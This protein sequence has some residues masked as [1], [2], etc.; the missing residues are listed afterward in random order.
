M[1]DLP[2]FIKKM[3]EEESNLMDLG[4]V[5]VQ[6]FTVELD[7]EFEIESDVFQE[8]EMPDSAELFADPPMADSIE[9]DTPTV[10]GQ[11][12]WDRITAQKNI[13]NELKAWLKQCYKQ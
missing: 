12:Y 9:F 1:H 4:M 3:E 5:P 13:A 7:N 8:Y 11:K 10:E 6:E 2:G